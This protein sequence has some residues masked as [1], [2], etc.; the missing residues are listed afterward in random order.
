MTETRN[1]FA[2]G[3]TVF[4]A[5]LMLLIGT[6]QAVEGLVALLGDTLYV[7][8]PEWTFSFD[9]TTWGW[10]HLIT[11]I[12]VAVAGYFLLT[13]AVWARSIAV[14]L[15]ALSALLN[16]LWL[17]YYPVWSVIVIALNVFVIWAL[18]AHGRDITR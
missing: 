16:F 9:V 10:I 14:F 17:P 2:V 18:T 15:A 7:V 11:G 6:F 4:A 5:V 12:V 13:G 8:G 1:S 3:L